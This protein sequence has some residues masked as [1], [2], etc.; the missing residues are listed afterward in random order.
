MEVFSLKKFLEGD[1][2]GQGEGG[3]YDQRVRYVRTAQVGLSVPLTVTSVA[4]TLSICQFIS[5]SVS[6]SATLFIS[7]SSLLS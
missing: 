3:T 1:Q 5:L 4:V 6:T 7:F 2:N